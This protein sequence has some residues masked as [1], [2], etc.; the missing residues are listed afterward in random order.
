MQKNI[1]DAL[2]LSTELQSVE[3]TIANIEA[4]I[5]EEG[6]LKSID[7]LVESCSTV[8]IHIEVYENDDSTQSIVVDIAHTIKEYKDLNMTFIYEYRFSFNKT[9]IVIHNESRIVCNNKVCSLEEAESYLNN[10]I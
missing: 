6:F 2:G 4:K 1:L 10:L 5:S 9:A 3:N 7:E 8:N